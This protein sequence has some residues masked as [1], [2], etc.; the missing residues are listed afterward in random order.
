MSDVWSERADAYRT[1]IE[2]R[3]GDDLDLIVEWASE[4]GG[5]AL[6]VAAGGGH[7]ARRLREAG[8]RVTTLDPAP[9]MRADVVARAEH[10]PFADGSFDVVVTRIAP[11][12][13]DDVRAAVGELAR[14]SRNLVIVEDTLFAS[15]AVEE[16][17]RLR[18]PTHVRSYSEDE[19]AKLL[20]AAGLEVE[21]VERYEKRRPVE[22]WLAR[23]GTG[24]AD[25]ERVRELLADRIRDGEYVD[26]K[27]LLKA[28]KRA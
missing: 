16:A 27:I 11:H 23:T 5:D 17:E 13:F 1:A 24:E 7:V 3:E 9:G 10:I 12:H 22:T 28:R 15:E 26:T 20:E 4:A 14:V 2:Q 18:D 19:W 6:D 8:L 25:A 21:D